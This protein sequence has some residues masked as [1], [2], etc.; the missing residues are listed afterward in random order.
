[1]GDAITKAAMALTDLFIRRLTSRKPNGYKYTD[2]G[3]MYLLV[4]GDS[5]YWRM[6]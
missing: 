3:E 2:G 4:K 5:K 6:D 1:M